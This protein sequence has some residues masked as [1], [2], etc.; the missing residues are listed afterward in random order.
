MK[1]SSAVLIG[2]ALLLAAGMQAQE[3]NPA[4]QESNATAPEQS[5]T[6]QQQSQQKK[7]SA[8]PGA[9]KPGEATPPPAPTETPQLPETRPVPG[10]TPESTRTPEAPAAHPEAAAPGL[11]QV[12]PEIHFEMTEHA[13]AVTHHRIVVNGHELRYTATAGRLPIKDAGG[14][15]QGLMFY[16]AY[17]LDG[18][19]AGRRPLTFAFNG[20]PGSASMWL[21]MGALGPRRV[22]LEKEGFLPAAP[23]RLEDNTDSI[24]TKTDLVLIDAMGTGFSRPATVT[25]GKKFWSVKGDIESFGEFIRLYIT[26]NERWSSPLF[27]FGESYGT[28]RAGGVAAWA[29]DHGISFN[30]IVLLSTVLSFETLEPNKTNDVPFPLILPSFTMIAGYHHKLAPALA[31]NIDQTRHEVEQWASRDYSLALAE[32]DALSPD[33]RRKVIDDLAKYT[34]LTPE[35][36]DETNLRVD[37]RGF[38]HRLLA[39][40]KL[41]VGRLDGRFKGPD[42]NGFES[43]PFYD[44]S[45]MVMP[46]FNSVL[47]DYLRREIG[48]R[49]DMPYYTSAGSAFGPAFK[50]DWG[51]ADEGFPDTASS[52]RQALVKNR[53]LKVLIMEGYYDLATPYYAVNYSINHLDLPA[54]YRSNISYATYYAGHMVYLDSQSRAKM[55][56]D[57][58]KFIDA[59]TAPGQ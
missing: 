44:P 59:C 42:P 25:E 45:N 58:S 21:H 11:L 35:F 23:Y 6:A 13:P 31:S 53:W 14:K 22:A 50:W 4:E 54:D 24:L 9:T 38:T 32:G 26:R 28:T 41:R 37:V 39:S 16:V 2:L 34:G 15:T 46:P 12:T 48:V 47:N 56:A 29:A 51:S 49:T 17:T 7:N 55:A 27:L 1:R 19:P 8:R 5:T 33:D 3:T 18:V 20:G 43:T 40:E 57:A 52:L 30:G 36:I 10:T